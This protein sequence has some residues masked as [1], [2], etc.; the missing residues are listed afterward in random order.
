MLDS[1]WMGKGKNCWGEIFQF[2]MV[3][4]PTRPAFDICSG[5]KRIF[6]ETFGEAVREI[7]SVHSETE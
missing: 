4:T 7:P 5:H 2:G 3:E 6:T 1:C